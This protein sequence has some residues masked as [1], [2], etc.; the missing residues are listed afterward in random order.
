MNPVPIEWLVTAKGLC[1]EHDMALARVHKV[2]GPDGASAF[3]VHVD[4]VG[5]PEMCLRDLTGNEWVGKVMAETFC[6]QIGSWITDDP[7]KGLGRWMT[8]PYPVSLQ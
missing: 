1:A 5:A 4:V 2:E 8:S 6:R 7:N 3:C